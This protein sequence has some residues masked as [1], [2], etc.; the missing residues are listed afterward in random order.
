MAGFLVTIPFT[1]NGVAGTAIVGVGT[2]FA[3]NATAAITL[4][5]GFGQAWITKNSAD[6]VTFGT[7]T[8]QASGTIPS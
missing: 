4:A 6:V 7:V 2:S 1:R 3:P 8:A 5:E